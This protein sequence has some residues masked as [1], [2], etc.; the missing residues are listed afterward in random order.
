MN[1]TLASQVPREENIQQTHSKHTHV[2]KLETGPT[3]ECDLTNAILEEWS[4]FPINT[5]VKIVGKALPEEL[6]L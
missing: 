6:K 4:K 1:N 5:L 3:S 2:R